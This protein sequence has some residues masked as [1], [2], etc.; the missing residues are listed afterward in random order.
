MEE[1]P[2]AQFFAM[3]SHVGCLQA[4]VTLKAEEVGCAAFV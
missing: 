4:E 2:V 3:R 1:M